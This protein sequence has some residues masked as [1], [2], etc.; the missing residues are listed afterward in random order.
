MINKEINVYIQKIFIIAYFML[1]T[2]LRP[3][4][5]AVSTWKPLSGST[6]L[7]FS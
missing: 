2:F 5:T 1:D 6:E 7:T 4:E 3:G